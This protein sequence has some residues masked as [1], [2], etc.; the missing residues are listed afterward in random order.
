MSLIIRKFAGCV[1]QN[2]FIM[3]DQNN[4]KKNAQFSIEI[5]D[6][7]KKALEGIATFLYY[8]N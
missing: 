2:N 5:K 3:E 4:N 6:A 8:F 7:P 1:I